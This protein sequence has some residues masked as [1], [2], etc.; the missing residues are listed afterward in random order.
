MWKK[1]DKVGNKTGYKKK[2]K[3]KKKRARK[4]IEVRGS[5]MREKQKKLLNDVQLA[6]N[7]YVLVSVEN[8]FFSHFYAKSLLTGRKL[9]KKNFWLNM[10]FFLRIGW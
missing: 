1:E 2:G 4:T 5:A 6:E 10:Q 3:G 7:L 9:F 8:L